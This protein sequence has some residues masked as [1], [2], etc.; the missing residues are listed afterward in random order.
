VSALG[1]QLLAENVVENYERLG[2]AKWGVTFIEFA[3]GTFTDEL[4]RG[5]DVEPMER[6][7]FL[8]RAETQRN[9]KAVR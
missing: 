6:I 4:A 8:A 9:K 5:G 1:V 7:G 2:G 3:S